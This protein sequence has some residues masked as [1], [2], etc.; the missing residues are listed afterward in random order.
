MA[1]E[2]KQNEQPKQKTEKVSKAPHKWSKFQ[3]HTEEKDGLNVYN[4]NKVDSE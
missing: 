3:T 4:F 2:A 1:D